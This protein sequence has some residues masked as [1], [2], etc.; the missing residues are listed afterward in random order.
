MS[1]LCLVRTWIKLVLL[2]S[3]T[4]SILDQQICSEN[5]QEGNVLE[6]VTDYILEGYFSGI[7]SQPVNELGPL[8]VPK[9]LP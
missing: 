4:V 9:L 5:Y 2:Q 8:T 6:P 7:L 1:G 3:G